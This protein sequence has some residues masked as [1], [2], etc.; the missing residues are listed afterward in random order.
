MKLEL[1]EI[2]EED[3]AKIEEQ[4]LAGIRVRAGRLTKFGIEIGAGASRGRPAG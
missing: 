4:V 3:F 1:G 2:S